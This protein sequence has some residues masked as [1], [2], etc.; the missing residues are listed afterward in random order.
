MINFL[1]RFDH[2]KPDSVLE[3]E[4]LEEEEKKARKVRISVDEMKNKPKIAVT[5]KFSKWFRKD[6]FFMVNNPRLPSC[7]CRCLHDRVCSSIS[8]SSDP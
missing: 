3:K 2:L 6:R 7:W 8:E 4:R 5:G 1:F